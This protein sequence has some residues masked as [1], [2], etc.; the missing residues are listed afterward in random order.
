[1]GAIWWPAARHVRHSHLAYRWQLVNLFFPFRMKPADGHAEPN[2][3][4]LHEGCLR[5]FGNKVFF[6]VLKVLSNNVVLYIF[7]V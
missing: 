6:A 3:L 5:V 1:V 2:R 4:T 7:G